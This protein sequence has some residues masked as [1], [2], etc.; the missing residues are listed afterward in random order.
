MKVL[1]V[2]DEKQALTSVQRLLKRRGIRDVMLCDNGAEAVDLIDRNR[3]DVVLLDLLMP[4]MSG[5]DVLEAAKPRH[6]DTEFI[7]LTALDEVDSSVKAIRL[8]AYDYLVK[9]VANERLLLS[10][11][12]AYERKGMLAGMKAGMTDGAGDGIPGAFVDVVTRSSRMKELLTFA[13]IMARSSQHVL[14]SGESGTG[15]E[16]V[17]EGIHRASPLKD[18]PFIA[19]NVASLPESLFESQLFGHRKG[20]FTGAS[21]DHRGFF[22]QAH[23]GTL[24]LD[25]IGEL[26]LHLQPKLLR[27]L[28]EKQVLR[29]GET[30]PVQVNVRIVSATNKNLDDACHEGRFRLDL[31][32]RLKSVHITLPPLAERTEDIPLLVQHFLKNGPQAGDSPCSIAPDALDILARRAYPG[33]IR[34]LRQVVEN[35]CVLSRGETITPVHLDVGSDITDPFARTLCSLK[36]NEDAHVVYVLE[37]VG[38]DRKA[39]A[40]I[41]GITVRQ[42]Q[43]KIVRL[44]EKPQWR[45]RIDDL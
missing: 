24:F 25:E 38:G 7:V 28:E 13:D 23:N 42:V 9:P 41:L 14:I 29:L 32:Y 35:A 36:D 43:R 15:K 30:R 2:D 18:G 16:L 4:E 17:A 3:F 37:K 45:K 33:N 21:C 5:I 10:L 12:R 1:I 26:P 31:L 19:I 22:E 27:V 40:L 6:P 44:R 11:Q 39:A 8:G 34:E 20:A